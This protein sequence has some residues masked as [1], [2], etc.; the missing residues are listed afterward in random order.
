MKHYPQVDVPFVNAT[1]FSRRRGVCR[2]SSLFFFIFECL[3]SRGS[4]GH[5]WTMCGIAASINPVMVVDTQTH[6]R[7]LN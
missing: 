1:A 3:G 2:N 6:A 5:I 4:L 7:L